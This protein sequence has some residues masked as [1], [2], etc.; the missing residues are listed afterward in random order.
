[1]KSPPH[2]LFYALSPTADLGAPYS[3][4]GSPSPT[5]ESLMS[6]VSGLT[7][8]LPKVIRAPIVKMTAGGGSE[9]GGLTESRPE[10]SNVL[11][12]QTI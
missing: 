6:F 9:S 7:H 5:S 4:T 1:M 3:V 11:T 2:M 10:G 12:L 8:M